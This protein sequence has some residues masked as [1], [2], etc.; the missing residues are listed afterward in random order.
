MQLTNSYTQNNWQFDKC[1]FVLTK[2]AFGQYWPTML[3][4]ND[5]QEQYPYPIYIR[6]RNPFKNIKRAIKFVDNYIERKGIK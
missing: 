4:R 2:N 6:D 3:I 1:F 5:T